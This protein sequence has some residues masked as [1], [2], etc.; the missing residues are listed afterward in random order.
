MQPR[1]ARSIKRGAVSL[2]TVLALASL[3][4][5]ATDSGT[6]APL[7]EGRRLFLQSCAGC[8]GAEGRGDGPEARLLIVPPANLR[9]SDVF[10]RLTDHDL[11]ALV[12]E[13]RRLHLE[14]QPGAFRKHAAE[15]EA[16]V[17]YVR[18]LATVDWRLADAGEDL[19][20]DRCTACHDRFG[21][22]QP[23][24]PAGIQ[25]PPRDLSQPELQR[26]TSDAALR[27][28]VRHGKERMPAL[29]PQLSNG[30]TIALVAYVRLLSD[31]HTRYIQYCETCHGPHG[32]GAEGVAAEAGAPRFA[33][34][35]RWLAGQSV[36]KTKR[37]AW[38]M[39]RDAKPA[40]PHFSYVLT[41]A[42]A[43][44]IVR[45]LRSLPTEPAPDPAVP[46]VRR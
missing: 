33:F 15:T 8:H 46:P 43:G 2:A 13:G 34:D 45:Y 4:G 1:I 37:A 21:A 44:A 28:L 20:L 39:L 6:A 25:A 41:Q 24:L 36:D 11:V 16:L 5:A 10:G 23:N 40:M 22:P 3:A 19:Y 42:Q 7:A 9:R 18:A 17:G 12:R 31:G 38:H 35:A 26:A 27:T 30:E 32:E 29:V 14:L